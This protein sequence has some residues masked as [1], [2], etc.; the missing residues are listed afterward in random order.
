MPR[1]IL[2]TGSTAKTTTLHL[3]ESQLGHLAKYSH[4]ANSSYG[5]PFDILNLHRTTLKPFEWIGIFFAAPFAVFKTLPTEK[6][7][8]VEADCDRPFEGN[9]LG[10]FLKPEVTIWLSSARTHSVNFEKLVG[11]KFGNVEEAIAFEYGNYLE[12]TSKLAI[13]NAD[14]PLITGQIKRTRAL[15]KTISVENLKYAISDDGT[16]F[17]IDNKKISLPYLLPE[18]TFYSI[19]GVIELLKYLQLS[20]DSTFKNFTLPPGRSSVFAGIKNT[21]IVDSSYN[22]DLSSMNA[23]LS[24]FDKLNGKKWVVLSDMIEQGR[25]EKEEHEK[26]ADIVAAMKLD[27]IILT[28]PRMGKYMLPRLQGSVI[29]GQESGRKEAIVYFDKPRQVLDYLEENIAGGELILFKGARFLEGV[30]EHLLE[31]K[32]DAEKLCRREKV[33]VE[34]RKKWKL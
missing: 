17:H 28:G 18:E 12:N 22:A 19:A 1:I 9:F 16:E 26:L 5:I 32:N 31:N 10:D 11:C 7:Y 27:K 4:K 2:I 33:W 20:F 24:M 3:V 14:N 21:L 6:I 30:I 8:I 13:I 23:I 15:V 34:R 25:I 29:S